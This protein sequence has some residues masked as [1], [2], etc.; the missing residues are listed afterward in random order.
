[1][2]NRLIAVLLLAF[3]TAHAA[4]TPPAASPTSWEISGIPAVN[5]NAD[6]G[7][8]YGVI[9]HA[10]NYG[11]GGAKP[12]R[13]TLQPQVF[14]TTKRRRDVSLFFDAPHVL[15]GAWRWSGYL[16]RGQQLA[17]PH[18]GI[19]NYSLYDERN[20]L[21]PN[22]HFYEY[23]RVGLRDYHV[24][25]AT[26]EATLVAS[27]NRGSALLCAG[28]CAAV[29]THAAVSRAPG[30]VFTKVRESRQFVDWIAEHSADLRRLAECTSLPCGQD[31]ACVSESSAGITGFEE[32]DDG[33][34]YACVTIPSLVV[35]T[36]GGGTGLP[37]QRAGHDLLDLEE[38]NSANE[39][40]EVCAAVVLAGELS[41]AGAI[42][43]NE[44]TQ[45]HG[46]PGRAKA[47][48]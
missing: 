19:G 1:M 2:R 8:G 41:I 26:T 35:G 40:A 28:G 43:A 10:F 15:P 44:F 25:L 36:V 24:P 13:Y 14:L 16:G 31:V 11:T 9:L 6:E 45:A 39:L 12:Y 18:Y 46:S 23:G 3:P 34:L 20:E 29:V 48:T 4:Q 27:Y 32:T 17:T 38:P 47:V 22:P 30:F 42:V 7:F 21:E 33:S 5:F 37:S